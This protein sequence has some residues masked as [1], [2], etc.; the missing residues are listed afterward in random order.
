[1]TLLEQPVVLLPARATTFTVICARCTDEH[2]QEFL[3]ATVTGTLRLEAAH[4]S[5]FCPHGHEVRVE[6]AH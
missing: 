5:A 3:R 1:M 6:R 2:P 4:G